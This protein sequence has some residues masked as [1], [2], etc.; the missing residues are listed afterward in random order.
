MFSNNVFQHVPLQCLYSREDEIDDET[1]W[2]LMQLNP[3]YR[4]LVDFLNLT[5]FDEEKLA[6]YA[7]RTF[8]CALIRRLDCC[9][10]TERN[11]IKQI[12]FLLFD[13][14]PYSRPFLLKGTVD[15]LVNQGTLSI[16]GGVKELLE[17]F[18]MLIGHG[19]VES[20]TIIQVYY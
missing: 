7:D 5:G 12:L 4:V 11:W 6:P 8:M 15:S 13:K 17:I 16:G 19:L 14:A 9:V 20:P 2:E 3:V 18:K 10:E 1:M